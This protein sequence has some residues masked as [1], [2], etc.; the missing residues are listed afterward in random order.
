MSKHIN[1]LLWIPLLY[2]VLFFT[3][4][5]LIISN[6]Q[7]AFEQFVLEKQSNYAS[8][9]AID[10]L[11]VASDISTD[12]GNGDVMKVEPSLAANDFAHT[13]CLDFGYIP[14]ESTLNKVKQENVRALLVCAW[15]GVYAYYKQQTETHAYELKQTPKIPY[16]YT[17]E[18]TN[19]QYCLT[20]DP[21]KGYWDYEGLEDVNDPE[22]DV[23]Y[24]L[25]DF[26]TYAKKPTEDR[27]RVAINERVADILNWALFNTYTA[28]TASTTVAIPALSNT[29]RGDQPIKG[30][31]VVAVVKGNNEVFTTA[32]VAESIAGAQIENTDHVVGYTFTHGP[33]KLTGKMWAYQ[34]FWDKHNELVQAAI[35]DSGRYFDDPF[36]AASAGYNDLNLYDE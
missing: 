7:I 10:E 36:A 3:F 34:S 19:E 20:L 1:L 9:S 18:K 6:E 17:N 29:I 5:V 4:S 13:L 11:L 33:N 26:D 27:Q 8:D 28:D 23:V 22:S 30:P 32:A 21:N 25:H 15:D 2:A 16:F 14:T 24:K 35:P 12:Y 31:A